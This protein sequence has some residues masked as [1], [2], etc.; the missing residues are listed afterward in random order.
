MDSFTFQEDVP[1]VC[2][3]A[4]SFPDGILEA[5][6]QLHASLPH[7]ER[8]NFYGI[9]YPGEDGSIVYKA[10]AGI[11]DSDGEE[12][13]RLERFTIKNGPYNS[14]YISNFMENPNSVKKAFEMLLEQH[15]VDPNGYCLEWYVNE[16]DVKCM[17]PLGSEYRPF[18][19]LNREYN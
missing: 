14:F 5:H 9:S 18:T 8:R 1:V 19:G 15:E 6:Q 7:N 10:A 17:V 16:H 3:T 11:M 13:N 2:V 12:L 4:T